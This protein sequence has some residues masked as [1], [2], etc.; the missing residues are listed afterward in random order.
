MATR[1]YNLAE[2]AEFLRMAKPTFRVYR[3]QIGG[4][5]IGKCWIFTEVEL[6]KFLES[7]RSIPISELKK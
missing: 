4:S 3:S 6:L 7:K 5:K 2:A 1:N